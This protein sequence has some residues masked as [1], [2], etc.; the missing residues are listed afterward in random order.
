MS[1]TVL[2][3]TTVL[4]GNRI[5]IS[6]PELREGS[7]ATV[8]IPFDDEESPKRPFREVLGDYPGKRLFKTAS[9][10]EAYLD[11]ERSSWLK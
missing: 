6:S 4:A 10:V 5:E 11:A 1:C 8:L 9:E 7:S 3:K 2:V